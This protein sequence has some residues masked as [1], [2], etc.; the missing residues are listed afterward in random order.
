MKELLSRPAHE[1]IKL[2]ESGELD[3]AALQEAQ[4]SFAQAVDLKL[5]AFISWDES[6]ETQKWDLPMVSEGRARLHRLPYAAKDIFTTAG[7]R[8]TAGS[9]ILDNYVP[10]YDAT[11]VAALRH[12]KNHLMGRPTWTSSPWA[13]RGR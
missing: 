8:T 10:P 2:I 12:E 6:V 5:N 7:L 11:C 1:V 13:A 3:H 9:K 4:F